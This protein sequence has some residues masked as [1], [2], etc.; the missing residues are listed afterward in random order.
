MSHREAKVA[1]YL[2]ALG[3]EVFLPDYPS[4]RDW[5]DR[6]KVLRLPLFPGYIFSRFQRKPPTVVLGAPGLAHVVGFADGPAPIPDDQIET[7][8]RLVNSG[9]S[10]CGFP[11]LSTGNIV[12]MRNGPLKGL[13]GRVE[14]IRSQFRLVVSVELLGRSVA[15]EVDPD[16]I[17]ALP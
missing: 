1:C 12:R 14:K 3:I 15:T 4:R 16:T 11:R 17:E 13:E 8:R 7:V 5:H 9:L 10:V 2:R 6:V